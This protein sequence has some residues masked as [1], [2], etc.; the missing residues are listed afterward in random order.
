MK[1]FMILC[2][3][4]A[5]LLSCTGPLAPVNTV[6]KTVIFRDGSEDYPFVPEDFNSGGKIL[7]EYL[8]SEEDVWIEGWVVGYVSGTKMNSVVMNADEGCKASNIVICGMSDGS[9][10]LMPVQ[11]STSPDSAKAVREQ[12]NLMDNPEILG[13]LIRVRGRLSSY[14]GTVGLKS[15]T[16]VI[17]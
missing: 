3:A 10:T 12:L 6:E 16:S 17:F 2:L 1:N 7:L 11:L 8:D 13:C 9:G 4:M 5:G 14:M 15:T